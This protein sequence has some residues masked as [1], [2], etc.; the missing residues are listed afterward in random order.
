MKVKDLLEF[1]GRCDPEA[2]L[3]ATLNGH[4]YL[5]IGAVAQ[6]YR[7]LETNEVSGDK[8]PN[9]EEYGVY[10]FGSDIHFLESEISPTDV[11]LIDPDMVKK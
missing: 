9:H 1:L 3:R 8:K 4:W 2:D 11:C 6:G 10:L 7:N 5:P